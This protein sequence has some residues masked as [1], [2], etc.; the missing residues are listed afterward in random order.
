MAVLPP[1]L[2]PSCGDEFV[3]SAT[4]CGSCDV[5]LV[6]ADTPLD[7]VRDQLPA[8]DELV[9]LR[10]ENA[11]WVDS[12]GARLARE[13]IPCRVEVL[14]GAGGRGP[15]GSDHSLVLLVRRQDLERAREIDHAL[16]RSQLPDMPEDVDT[17]VSETEHCPACGSSIA[18]DATE[19]PDCGLGFDAPGGD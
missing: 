7:P 6:G 13:E 10:A 14:D 15:R 3:H 9:P 17:S 18:E 2:C 8:S 16:L 1:K 19:C 12:L 11:A 4:R 5:D